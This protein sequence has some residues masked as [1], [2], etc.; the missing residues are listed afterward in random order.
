[1]VMFFERFI[2]KKIF[3]MVLFVIAFSGCTNIQ[4]N[5][6]IVD[7]YIL[8]P[9]IATYKT[10]SFISFLPVEEQK[11]AIAVIQDVTRDYYAR[12]L[13]GAEMKQLADFFS[14]ERIVKFQKIY[15]SGVEPS[16]V[17]V[18]NALKATEEFSVAT[19]IASGSFADGLSK[20]LEES[21]KKEFE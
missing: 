20:C 11:K 13:S 5:E 19:K 6:S 7:T 17:V 8:P 15:T 10:N 4:Q 18:E 1:M 2:G 21:L 3:C 9:M 12:N 14:D 16:F